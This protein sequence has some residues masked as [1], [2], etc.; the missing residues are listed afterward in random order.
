VRQLGV[1]AAMVAVTAAGTSAWSL[2]A[3]CAI[4]SAATRARSG[5]RHAQLVSH[6]TPGRSTASSGL[7]TGSDIMGGVVG[8]LAVLALAYLIVTF[9][10]HRVTLA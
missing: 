9:I 8:A 6:I 7:R 5:S 10:R 1:L 2:M 4:A 3:G